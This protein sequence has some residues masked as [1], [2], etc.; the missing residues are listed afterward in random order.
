MIDALV[1]QPVLRAWNAAALAFRPNVRD[2]A[3]GKHVATGPWQ[4]SRKLARDE[5]E[6]A[7]QGSAA[8]E[9]ANHRP[10]AATLE[11]RW[12]TRARLRSSAPSPP[13]RN[14]TISLP[15]LDRLVELRQAR[16]AAPKI[17]HPLNAKGSSPRKRRVH[18]TGHR[19]VAQTSVP[20]S[21]TN[22]LTTKSWNTR[23]RGLTNGTLTGQDASLQAA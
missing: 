2:N 12:K 6:W 8:G 5:A 20:H 11:R 22:S 17:V 1:S 18:F 7:E 3:Y 9:Q 14:S 10:R 19:L 4:P 21:A 15:R 23:N 16:Q 13:L